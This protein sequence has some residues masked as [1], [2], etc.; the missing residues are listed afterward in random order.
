MEDVTGSV[1]N[2]DIEFWESPCRSLSLVTVSSWDKLRP[3]LKHS[4]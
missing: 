4:A 1:W 2:K 3:P